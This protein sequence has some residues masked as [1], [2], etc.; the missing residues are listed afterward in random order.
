VIVDGGDCPE[1]CAY[2]YCYYPT[3]SYEYG[4]GT[5]PGSDFR[6]TPQRARLQTNIADNPGFYVE[7]CEIVDGDWSCSTG[8]PSESEIGVDWRADGT[9]EHFSNGTQRSKWGPYTYQSHG[10]YRSSSASASGHLGSIQV[11]T[12]RGSAEISQS[13]GGSISKVVYDEGGGPDD[14]GVAGTGAAGTGGAAGMM[15]VPPSGP[16]KGKGPK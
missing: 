15:A 8:T 10:I 4:W 14:A 1:D 7:R 12:G 6:V 9:Y 16:G 2:Q 11:S 13:Q 5:I 3:I